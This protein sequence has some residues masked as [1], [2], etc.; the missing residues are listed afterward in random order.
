MRADQRASHSMRP[1]RIQCGVSPYAEGSADVSFGNTRVLVTAS[2]E[3]EV[4]DWLKARQ[5][6]WITAEY[7]MLPRSTHTRN[8]REA[9]AGKQS[10]RTLEIQRFIGRALRAAIDLR[11]I[12][13][14]TIRLDCDVLCADGGTR[15]AAASGAWVALAQALEYLERER[16][17]SGRV[18][19]KQVAAVS[20]GR[21]GSE[22]L[23][24]LAYEEDSRAD[25]DLNLVFSEDGEIVEI[26]GTAERKNF[27]R[28]ELAPLIDLAYSGVEVI[29]SAQ[30]NALNQ[31]A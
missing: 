1:V 11:S 9:S 13:P 25:F 20:V 17:V 31:R 8:R 22:Y 26:Q 14:V 16:L 23:L 4:P 27:R 2:V 18:P 21:I 28:D 5:E 6:G 7:G 15:T 3:R 24:D 19:I 12:G 10:G 29:F 30:R